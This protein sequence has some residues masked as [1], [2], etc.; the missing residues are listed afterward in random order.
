[1]KPTILIAGATGTTGS[2]AIKTLLEL[3]VCVFSPSVSAGRR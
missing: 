2:T 3:K 1:M